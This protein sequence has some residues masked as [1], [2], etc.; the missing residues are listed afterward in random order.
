MVVLPP[1]GRGPGQLDL[2]VENHIQPVAV[3][4]LVEQTVAPGQRHVDHAGPQ[5]TRSLVVERFK[6]WRPAEHILSVSH[7]APPRTSS[8]ISVAHPRAWM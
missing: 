4:A 3:I 5:G 2:A 7:V 1:I 8:V 6:Q